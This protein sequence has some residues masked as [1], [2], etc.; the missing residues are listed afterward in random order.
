MYDQPPII[1]KLASPECRGWLANISQGDGQHEAPVDMNFEP[2]A[3]RGAG[4]TSDGMEAMLSASNDVDFRH[5]GNR[6]SA[7]RQFDF[8]FG[9]YGMNSIGENRCFHVCDSNREDPGAHRTTVLFL[10]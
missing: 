5:W 6:Q 8:E 1:L 10:E 3:E 9:P 2:L 4:I 7:A